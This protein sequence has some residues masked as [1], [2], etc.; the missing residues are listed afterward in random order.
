MRHRATRALLPAALAG[1]ALAAAATAPSAAGATSRP[2][3]PI[4]PIQ[5]VTRSVH[6]AYASCPVK[7]VVLTLSVPQRSYGPG[8]VVRYRVALHNTSGRV[9][10]Y[11]GS[12]SSRPGPTLPGVVAGALLGPCGPL[13]ASIVDAKGHVV[14]PGVGAISCPVILGPPLAAHATVSTTG[15]WD[16]TVG[17]GLRPARRGS[18]APP[19][20]YRIVIG[21]KVSLPI[22]VSGVTPSPGVTSAP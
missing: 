22:T 3:A 9:C 21:G 14:S 13:P 11:G 1:V 6:V 15:T 12:T 7:D 5:V 16:Q 8:Q 2:I 20:T 17:G 19:G 10:G 18:P 4:R